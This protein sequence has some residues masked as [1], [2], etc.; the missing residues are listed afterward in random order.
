MRAIDYFDK[1]AE[2]YAERT[3]LVDGGI[4]YSY[5]QLRDATQ[6]LAGSMRANGL[7][8][9]DRVAIYSLNDARVLV[10][11]LGIMRA[12]GAWVPM[13]YRNAID[14]NI[15]FMQYAEVRWLFYH[16]SFQEQVEQIRK[17]VPSSAQSDLH[18]CFQLE[19]ILPWNNS[20]L[21]TS[22]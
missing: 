9:E 15:E 6:A 20:C 8:A 11:M 12:G 10:C 22:P 18:R 14:A 2:E 5:A 3:A 16:S 4:R 19:T 7:N 1:A 17:L 13:N 21:G